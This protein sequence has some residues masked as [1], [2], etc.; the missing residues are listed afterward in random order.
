MNNRIDSMSNIEN[1]NILEVKDLEV[2]IKLDEGILTPVRGVSFNI[3]EQETLGLV[4]E[5]GCGKSLTSKAIL[6]INNKN[7]IRSGS[8]MFKMDNRCINLLEYK[9]KSKELRK[10]RGKKISMIF[11]E[12]MTSF[13]PL[14]TVGN[15]ISEAV[16]LHI[17]KNKK[18]AEKIS[19]KMMTRVGIADA[20][21][22]FN[23]YPHEFSGGMLQ[24]ALIAMS[25]VCNPKLLIADEPTTALDVTIQAQILELMKE[26]QKE[27]KMSILYITHDLGTV[28]K[29]CDKVAVMYLGRIVE[30]ASVYEIFKNPM[31]PYT[32]GLIGSVHNI[33]ASKEK[34]FSIEGTVPLAMNLPDRCSFYDRCTSRDDK[35]CLAKEPCLTQ[36]SE[37]HYVACYNIDN[38]KIN[39]INK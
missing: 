28:A 35:K 12:P 19:I 15:Q 31:H 27:F 22:R 30:Y 2:K 33:G 26:L 16:R 29:M 24:R 13:S 1:T 20:S 18:E 3:K 4:G 10:I 37:D 7:C 9:R 17:T 34:L 14:Y 6:G 8:V 38:N 32:R 5:S 36:V 23:Q 25:L 39:D 21:K 11:Q